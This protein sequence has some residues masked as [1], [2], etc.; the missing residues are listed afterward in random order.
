[1]PAR[2]ES[3][4]FTG[5]RPGK[6][7]WRYDESDPRCLDLKRRMSDAVETA[8]EQGFRH[9]L[10][11]MAQGCDLYFCECVLALRAR[12]P[13][14]T[15]EAAIPCPGQAEAWPADQRARYERLVAACD[16]ETLVSSQY[17]P[18][19]MQRRD[20]YMVDHA[21]LLIAAFDGTAGGT[22]YT[23]EYAMRRRISIVDLD[24]LPRHRRESALPDRR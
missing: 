19:C 18:S 11:G 3:C 8:Y 15:V 13:D 5:H 21:A 16:L 12:R 6:L 9:F 4:C 23:V 17:S 22:R 10:C 2:Q 24:I 1:M 7:P 14:V 20:R